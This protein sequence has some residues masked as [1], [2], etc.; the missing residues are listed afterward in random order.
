MVSLSHVQDLV[1]VIPQYLE[2]EA[3]AAYLGMSEEV[4]NNVEKLKKGLLTAFSESPFTA[5]V[6]LKSL[7]WTG[8]PVDI[9]VM[10]IRKMAKESGF[11][12]GDAL[13]HVVRLAL[14]TGLPEKVS[15]E[16]KQV[17]DADNLPVAE[18]LDKARI[19]MAK[20]KAGVLSSGAEACAEKD[21][22]RC[23]MELVRGVL[24]RVPVVEVKVNGRQALGLVDS[25][26]SRSMV[27]RRRPGTVAAE[28]SALAF[29]GREV[30]CYGHDTVEL[31]IG[32]MTINASVRV[33][34]TLVGDVDIILGMDV[35]ETLGGVTLGDNKVRFGKDPSSEVCP[36]VSCTERDPDIEDQLF[37]L[38]QDLAHTTHQFLYVTSK[39]FHLHNGII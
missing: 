9:Y 32:E 8:Q 36:K 22:A 16:L 39:L 18:L 25:G 37:H 21:A 3:L 34:D 5:F 10:E 11:D 1:K 38:T 13:E 30:R 6:K 26:C 31:V 28:T 12:E 27:R 15:A 33:I 20:E 7:R 29:D 2:G 35:I 19:L 17:K 4:K 23:Q 14:V 24:D